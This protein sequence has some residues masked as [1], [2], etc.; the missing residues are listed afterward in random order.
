MPLRSRTTARRRTPTS[1]SSMTV[2]EYTPAQAAALVDP[3]LAAGDNTLQVEVGGP[4]AALS[5]APPVGSEVI[6]LRRGR[7]HPAV[8][9]RLR[10]RDGAAPDHR[11]V[12]ARCRNGARRGAP[13]RGRRPRLGS[14]DGGDGRHRCR[15][16]LRPAHRH[17]LPHQPRRRSGPTPSDLH[18]DRDGRS[19]SPVRRT[20]GHRLDAGHPPDGP[21]RHERV[22][23][24]RRPRRPGHRRCVADAAAGHA[25]A[26]PV[27]ASNACTSRS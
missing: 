5:Q 3:I 4:V 13:S 10:G 11:A 26:S 24:H 17:P 19:R 25:R 7:R 12:R 23:L 6:G 15:Y 27:A 20:H 22:R 9:L 8:H 14:R 16:R 21:A 18:R 2:N 1:P